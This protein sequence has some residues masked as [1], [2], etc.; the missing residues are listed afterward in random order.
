[1]SWRLPHL[2]PP[3]TD[4]SAGAETYY[5]NFRR[6]ILRDGAYAPPVLK[7]GV[8][9]H[10]LPHGSASLCLSICLEYSPDVL[11]EKTKVLDNLSTDKKCFIKINIELIPPEI[12]IR[13]HFYNGS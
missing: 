13:I 6:G 7:Q 8:N 4:F 9:M 1:M 5:L 12:W 10:P 11:K 2:P 3:L